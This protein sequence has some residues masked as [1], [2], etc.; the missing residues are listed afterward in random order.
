M[1]N[2]NVYPKAK[3]NKRTAR[4][5]AKAI[6]CKHIKKNHNRFY[7]LIKSII[8]SIVISIPLFF[9]IALVIKKTNFPEEYLPPALL[10]TVLISIVIAAF[11]ST[12]SAQSNGWFNGTLVGLIYSLMLVIMKWIINDSI[13]FDKNTFSTILSGLLIGSICGIAGLNISDTIRNKSKK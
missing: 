1:Q 3:Y 5:N 4:L 6:K 2:A 7:Y 11:Y 9:A 12:A 13:F 8:I 10:C